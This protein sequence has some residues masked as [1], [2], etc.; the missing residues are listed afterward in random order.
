MNCLRNRLPGLYAGL[1]R[2]LAA[3]FVVPLAL[4][5][6]APPVHAAQR[7]ETRSPIKH[8]IVII[9]ENRSFDHV[10]ATYQPRHGQTVDNLLSRGIV[11]AD[12]TPGP[13]YARA[14]QRT[15]QDVY[16]APYSISPGGRQAYATLPPP[17]AGGPAQPYF[18]PGTAGAVL[19]F[20]E[21]G[22]PA[23]YL[24]Y[25]TT[26]G[27]GLAH[28]AV[29]T[30]IPN[31]S[32]LPPGPFQ[33]TSATLPYDAYTNSPVHRFYQM[34]QQLDCS[35]AHGR[36]ANPSGCRA[37]L[38][39]W[40]ETTVG[41]GTNG[42]AQPDVASTCAT[43]R[44]GLDGDGLLQRPAGR[45]AV[46]QAAGRRLCDER[47]L[48]PGG[49]W[50]APAPTTSC[51]ARATRSGIRTATATRPFRP[52]RSRSPAARPMPAWSRK[53]RTRTRRPAPTTGTREDGYGGGSY[54]S[55]SYGGGTYSNCADPQR[56]AS[57]RCCNYLAVAAAAGASPNC[58]AGPLLPAQ[59][60]QPRLL[61]QRQQRRRRTRTTPTRCSPSRR[62]TCATSAMHWPKRTS[63]SRTTATSGTSTSPTPTS[64]TAGTTGQLL[65]HLQLLPVHDVDHDERPGRARRAHQ[66]HAGPVRGHRRG[67]AAGGLVRQAQRHRRRPPGLVQAQPVRGLRQEDRRCGA[68]PIRTCGRTRPS[69]SRSTRAA[70]T[71]T[72]ATCSRWTS[73]ATARASRCIV[74][75]PYAHGGHISHDYTDHVSILKFIERNWGLAPLT[76]R[77]RDNLPNPQYGPAQ[78]LRAGQRRR[79]SA[80]CSTCSASKRRIAEACDRADGAMP[81]PGPGCGRAPAPTRLAHG[82]AIA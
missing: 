18:A 38:F 79:P 72:R 50:A 46:L 49:R 52:T 21:N 33:L 70:A 69:S 17:L 51:W 64:S 31:A 32:A 15:A 81:P 61:R 19:A 76:H 13:Q 28:G 23:D 30:R 3:G 63:R 4:G 40:V 10:F 44:R 58:E 56:R 43:T 29:D 2:T 20:Y 53:S 77:S 82:D 16:P 12:G 41:A 68:R 25:L 35:A 48:P 37:D 39:P 5:P 34:W 36:A 73:S 71:T 60:L 66:G 8:V 14:L 24:P 55:P 9:G 67:H 75:S 1:R 27:T 59:Q 45:R 54:G 57:P 22:L 47:Q 6:L 11:N 65:Q 42:L 78:P 62:R 7:H 74:V 80:T 26:G